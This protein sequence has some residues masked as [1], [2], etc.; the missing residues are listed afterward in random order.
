MFLVLCYMSDTILYWQKSFHSY[1]SKQRTCPAFSGVP[2]PC[3]QVLEGLGLP[4][5]SPR[6]FPQQSISLLL[7]ADSFLLSWKEFRSGCGSFFS[8]GARWKL[9]KVMLSK[10]GKYVPPV[11]SEP[12]PA[13]RCSKWL[14]GEEIRVLSSERKILNWVLVLMPIEDCVCHVTNDDVV[15]RIRWIEMICVLHKPMVFYNKYITI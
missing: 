13:V 14:P 3:A 15:I 2:P 8:R 6:L 1:A 10:L 12:D 9:W 4:C 5:T 7:W 11:L